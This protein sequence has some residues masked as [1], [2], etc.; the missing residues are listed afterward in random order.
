LCARSDRVGTEL[1]RKAVCRLRMY[2]YGP[3]ES[4]IEQINNSTG[5]V[6]Y[7]HH[8][9]QGSTRLITGSTGKVEGKCSYAAY[10][11]P[12][13]EGTST[14]PLG[15]DGQY[16]STDTG[17]IYLRN[18]VYDPMTAQF[19]TRD[20]AVAITQAPYN[21]ADDNPV[22]DQDRTGLEEET[23]YC[24]LICVSAP[25]GSSGPGQPVQEIIEKNW[26]E[27]E[28]GAEVIGKEVG[29]IWNEITGGGGDLPKREEADEKTHGKIPSH[30]PTGATREELE[31]TLEDLEPSMPIR[32]G[33]LEERGE[34]GKHRRRLEEERKLRRQIEETLGCGS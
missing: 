15:Y 31:E 25:G 16:T 6:T 26:H 7:L 34:H 5:T 22:N 1:A 33:E 30:P 32:E 28:G 29:S 9:Q 12:T 3:S 14:T 17:L 11:T 2:V 4:R 23:L 13:C 20:P 10:G 18:R 21:Y 19:L 24:S 27:F 8:D